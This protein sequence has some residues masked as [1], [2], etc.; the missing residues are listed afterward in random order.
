MDRRSFLKAVG[1]GWA[2]LAA[3]RWARAAAPKRGDGRP[4]IVVILCDDLGYSDL[5]CYGGEIATPHLDRLAAEGLRFT[6]FYN[7]AKCAPT[8]ATL[9][10]GTYYQR[11]RTMKRPNTV[12][13]AEVL[14]AAGYTTLMAGKWHLPRTPIQRGFER[15]FG[16]LGGATNYFK[17]DGSFRLDEQRFDVPA[18]GFYCT[19]AFTDHAVRF[20]EQAAAKDKPFFLYLAYNAPHY[21]LQAW[22]ADIDRYRGKFRKGWDRLRDERYRRMLRMKLIRPQWALTKRDER[23]PAW[24]E[25]DEKRRA[26]EDLLM[27]VYAAMVECMDRNIGRLLEKLKRLGVEDNTLVL[28]LSDNGGCPYRN[29]RKPDSVPGGPESHRTYNTP[30]A[31]VSNTPFRLYKRYSHEGGTATPLIARWPKVIRN[32][33][34][35]SD[36][37]GHIID[38][39]P[40]CAELAGAKHPK[41][42]GG[43][44][45][46]PV[47]G[48][49]LVPILH[50]RR[51]EPHEH[52]FWEYAR[53][54]AVR[55]GDWKLV[56]ERGKAWELYDMSADRCETRDLSA[57]HPDLV[58][59]LR[60][61]YNAWAKDAGAA[62]GDATA[63]DD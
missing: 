50:G 55:K 36:Q 16:F 22:P 21:P 24:E 57:K 15:F 20:V 48:K 58:A 33:G 35:L 28:F 39:M 25:L 45:I 49:S 60:R 6:R 1:L 12:T 29:E 13:I 18:K 56:A 32:G 4:N 59:E 43:S 42:F 27:A 51:R 38:I 30:W 17:G 52:L 47:D 5:G 54:R 3:P 40:T 46:L 53:H 11:S 23:V 14:R 8:R 19:D 7:C 61:A 44:D 63:P 62:P 41:A 26:D 37:V 10:T 2:S 34:A 31:N 9:L